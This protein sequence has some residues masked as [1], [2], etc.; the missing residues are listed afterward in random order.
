VNE[1]PE[2]PEFPEIASE[3]LTEIETSMIRPGDTV[4]FSTVDHVTHEQLVKI[5]DDL[6]A[7]LPGVQ[8][9]VVSRVRFE[10]TYRPDRDA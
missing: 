3:L 4:L 1:L 9:V 2:L 10:A 8:V 6:A 5:R 7:K